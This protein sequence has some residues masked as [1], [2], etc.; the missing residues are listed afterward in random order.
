MLRK[1]TF[2][3]MVSALFLIVGCATDSMEIPRY[4]GYYFD[5]K[6]NDANVVKLKDRT[7]IPTLKGYVRDVKWRLDRPIK[8]NFT[9]YVKANKNTEKY[10]GKIRGTDDLE[11]VMLTPVNIETTRGLK[12][13]NTV[14]SM[15]EQR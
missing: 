13:D 8:G 9:V 12:S 3:M 15:V 7:Q 4:R 1:N 14:Q 5:A 11:I 2:L 6:I 10:I